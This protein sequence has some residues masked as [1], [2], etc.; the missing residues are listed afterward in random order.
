MLSRIESNCAPEN[1]L[2]V[3]VSSTG[4]PPAGKDDQG[5]Y[6]LAG[7]I[8]PMWSEVPLLA[9]MHMCAPDLM[10]GSGR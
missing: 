3:P 9:L 5:Y 7:N 10:A 1:T 6:H 2:F 8:K 4:C